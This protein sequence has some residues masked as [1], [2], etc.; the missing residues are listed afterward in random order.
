LYEGNTDEHFKSV[1]GAIDIWE[2]IRDKRIAGFNKNAFWF[3][4]PVYFINHL[5][6]M[7]VFEI[8]PYLGATYG[9]GTPHEVTVVDNVGFAPYA[10]GHSR[11]LPSG[12]FKPTGFFNQDYLEEHRKDKDSNGKPRNY[13]KYYYAG[14]DFGEGAEPGKSE[15][16]VIRSL[17]YGTVMR[18]GTHGLRNGREN[19]DDLLP[20][21]IGD[22]IIVQDSKDPF[23]YY[24]LVH[25][26]WES[27][28]DFEI[29]A[30]SVISPEQPVA[31]VGHADTNA[32]KREANYHLH[33]S[34]IRSDKFSN[35]GDPYTSSDFPQSYDP[36]KPA[37][38]D[39]K[40]RF[41]RE[42]KE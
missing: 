37:I 2:S 30:G 38:L 24:L 40:Y 32:L 1:I 4:H 20:N 18:V 22:F 6:K 21:G 26:A 33:V 8:N 29:E 19:K 36:S 31:R 41:P 39:V 10:M 27:Y 42:G 15:S 7:S 13:T 28:K 23:K 11:A 16:P 25:L 17:I 12:Y 5:D 9:K 3:A 14:V 35:R 34:V